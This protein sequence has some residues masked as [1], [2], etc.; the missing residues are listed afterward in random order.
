MHVPAIRH[1]TDKAMQLHMY[2][3]MWLAPKAQH[4][5]PFTSIQEQMQVL[6]LKKKKKNRCKSVSRRG[7]ERIPELMA[8]NWAA[9]GAKWKQ[10]LDFGRGCHLFPS[11]NTL[12]LTNPSPHSPK[13]FS[14]SRIKCAQA[15]W[16][17]SG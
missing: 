14:G 10:D 6:F 13:D 4:K 3:S 9:H 16:M 1:H 12:D 8:T 11:P 2:N 7:A 17:G 5:H 15:Q